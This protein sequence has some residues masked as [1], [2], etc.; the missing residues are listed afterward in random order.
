MRADWDRR[1]APAVQV[2]IPDQ[3]LADLARHSLV[4]DLITRIGPFPK[5]G[6]FDR[7]YG[8]SEHDGF[9]DTFTADTT[10]MLE[11]GLA[12]LARQYLDNYLTHFVRDDGSILYRGPEV[13]Q[14]GRMLTV[15]AQY[16]RYTGD[17]KLLVRHRKPLDAITRVLLGFRAKGLTLPAEDAAHGLLAGWSEA[18]SCLDPEP[19]RYMQPYF[20][21]STEAARGFEELGQV[22]ETIGRKEH[23]REI[24]D[25]GRKL[26]AESM[27][28][29]K[30]IQKAIARSLFTNTAPTC[31]PAIAGAR[32][33][34]HVAVA[35]DKLDPQFR[36]YRAYSEM[37]Y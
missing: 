23:R 36:A 37:L 9:P 13:G 31:L 29:T 20:S 3:R 5:Y 6:V 28:L 16:A 4:R 7:G 15:A 26:R 35:R 24:T 22:W 19:S 1:L 25:W 18:D 14:Y 2:R 34:F 11:W 32:E 17:D 12:D 30:D 10:A 21:N 27:A 8:G 33:P